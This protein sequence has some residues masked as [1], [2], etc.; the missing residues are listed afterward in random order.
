M[1]TRKPLALGSCKIVWKRIFSLTLFYMAWEPEDLRFSNNYFELKCTFTFFKTLFLSDKELFNI[2]VKR[3]SY[4]SLLFATNTMRKAI[5]LI[6]FHWIMFHHIEKGKRL[7]GTRSVQ[8]ILIRN[9]ERI[10]I[11]IVASIPDCHSGDACGDERFQ[12]THGKLIFV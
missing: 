4:Y 7:E 9:S 11:S 2:C 6:Q 5:T 8:L 1:A 3:N 12:F 10:P